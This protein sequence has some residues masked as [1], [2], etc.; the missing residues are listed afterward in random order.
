MVMAILTIGILKTPKSLE[1]VNTKD[2]VK[3]GLS[4]ALGEGL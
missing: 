3:K 2:I 1:V 4:V